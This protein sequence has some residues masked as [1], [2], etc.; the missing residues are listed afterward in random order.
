MQKACTSERGDAVI[1][2]QTGDT[3]TS[4]VTY[5]IGK[6]D[7]EVDMDV[8]VRNCKTRE[9]GTVQVIFKF[10]AAIQGSQDETLQRAGVAFG[11]AI[12]Q[13]KSLITHPRPRPIRDCRTGRAVPQVATPAIG[14][15]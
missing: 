14:C 9:A 7:T 3:R 8:H 15:Q 1:S 11:K 4:R 2:A 5:L 10:D 6:A 13:V 12:T